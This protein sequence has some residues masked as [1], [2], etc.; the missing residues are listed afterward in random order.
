MVTP[1]SPTV[2]A[3]GTA[4]QLHERRQEDREIR[5]APPLRDSW[6]VRVDSSPLSDSWKAAV[7]LSGGDCCIGVLAFNGQVRRGTVLSSGCSQSDLAFINI[8]ALRSW[9]EKIMTERDTEGADLLIVDPKEVADIA[10]LPWLKHL[11][12]LSAGRV[13]VPDEGDF[14]TLIG[15]RPAIDPQKIDR[16]RMRLALRILAQ[17]AATHVV[18]A[19]RE[20]RVR[21]LEGMIDELAPAFILV[22]R[23]AQVFWTNHRA[24]IVL[25]QRDFLVRNG[26]NMLASLTAQRTHALR[27]AIANIARAPRPG[28]PSP[29]DAH[30][31]LQ[32]S[33][34]GEHLIVLRSVIGRNALEGN[35]AVLVIV[36][37]H[38]GVELASRLITVYGLVPSEARLLSALM[39]DRSTSIAAAK[40]GITEQTAKTYLKR[41]YSKLGVT[42]QLELSLLLTSIIPP[43]RGSREQLERTHQIM[44]F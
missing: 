6:Q 4:P 17:C 37:Q 7:D 5:L 27:E 18:T 38:D 8:E 12:A 20:R 13:S 15:W 11:S 42:S 2:P 22:N 32:R 21:I 28:E 29:P 30:L 34:G 26:G 43:L 16:R 33:T 40:V 9:L 44:N 23:S 41:I 10:N 1:P 3:T 39:R 14:W 35:D 19:R 36:P 24:E 31:L 25:A